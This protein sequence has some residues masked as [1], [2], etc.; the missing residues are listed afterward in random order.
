MNKNNLIDE[1][2]TIF[3]AVSLA[4][5]SSAYAQPLLLNGSFESPALPA[6]T[7]SLSSPASW[8]GSGAFRIVNGNYGVP[9]YPGPHDGQ[10][11]AAIGSAG[12]GS[13]LVQ[14]FTKTNAGTHLL[15]WFDNTGDHPDASPYTVT[16]T[17]DGSVIASTNL[18]A[19]HYALGWLPHTLQMSLSSG[20]YSIEF[21]SFVPA[22]G[23]ATLLD[24][25]AFDVDLASTINVS[26][27]DICWPGRADLTYKVQYT[28]NL[29]VPTWLDLTSPIVGTGTN[30]IM[31]RINPAQNRFYR[32]I[33]VP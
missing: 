2:Q 32:V 23:L 11:Y 8:Q 3:L 15:S 30:C 6:N 19:S 24:S 5:G 20:T 1:T 9:E 29:S 28:M 17:K 16:V 27:V 13:A 7:I 25:I 14:V 21:R 26:A 33:R 31:D 4:L 18:N 22:F 12:F 10:Q